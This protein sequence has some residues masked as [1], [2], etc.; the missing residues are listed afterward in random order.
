M[1]YSEELEKI[2]QFRTQA[3]ETERRLWEN[4]EK[5]TA[6][7]MDVLA[8][9]LRLRRDLAKMETHFARLDEA[10]QSRLDQIANQADA[11]RELFQKLQRLVSAPQRGNPDDAAKLEV[12]IEKLR[13]EMPRN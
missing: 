11:R 13:K 3:A 10:W 6:A 1:G 4:R 2:E 12:L 5:L 8:E 7:K 9:I